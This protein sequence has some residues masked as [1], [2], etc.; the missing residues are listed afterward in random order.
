MPSVDVVS[1]LDMQEVDNA[2]N[3]VLKE[4]ASRYDFRG[5]TTEVELV[6]NDKKI[7]LLVADDMKLR[8]VKEMLV[9]RFV[10]RKLSAKILD[11][12][13][14][15]PASQGNIRVE[16]TLREGLTGDDARRA[17][18]ITKDSKLKVQASIQGDQVRLS[19]NKIDDLQ[20]IMQLLREDKEISVP[21]QFVNMKR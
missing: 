21:L 17:V 16:V 19:G 14:E 6:K 10:A 2:V 11:F 15:E 8:A 4:I 7:K 12:G 1:K 5:S 20:A 3:A 18:K 13:K 9:G